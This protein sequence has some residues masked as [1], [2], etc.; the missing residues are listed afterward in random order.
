MCFS[1]NAN[2][3]RFTSNKLCNGLIGLH[4]ESPNVS[5]IQPL[6]GI[7]RRLKKS[8]RKTLTS[9]KQKPHDKG[10]EKYSLACIIRQKLFLQEA[11]QKNKTHFNA[12]S[13][14]R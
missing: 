11:Q 13:R 14:I 5:Q 6:S 8:I 4:F 9:L 3:E 1:D 2:F 10:T 7:G 12:L